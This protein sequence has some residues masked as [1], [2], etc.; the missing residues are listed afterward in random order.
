L[1]EVFDYIDQHRDEY[2]ALLQKFV[3]QPSIANSGE[4]MKEM[5]DLLQSTLKEMGVESER[6][7]TDGYPIIYAEIPGDSKKTLTFYNHYDVQPVDPIDEWEVPPFGGTI[8]DGKVISRGTADNKG[9]LL[10]RLCAIDAYRKVHGS[11]PVSIKLVYE[12]EEEVGSPNLGGFVK[13]FPE[14]AQSDGLV[15]E[16]GS[17]EIDGPAIITL[18]VKGVCYVELRVRT[19]NIDAHSSNAP[20]WKNAAW[21]LVWALSTLKNEKD[22]I[23]IDGFFDDIIPLTP[24]QEALL[25][26]IPYDEEGTLKKMEMDEFVNGITGEALKRKLITQPTCNIC[27]I[28]AGYVDK[29]SKTVLPSYAFAKVDFRL[30]PN[31]T[32]ERVVELLRKHLDK[33]GFQDVEIVDLHGQPPYRSEGDSDLAKAAIEAATEVYG[34]PPAVYPNNP[35]TMGVYQFCHVTGSPAVMYGVGNN[36]SQ[37]HAPNENIFVEDY[38]LS[39]KMSALV[40]NKFGKA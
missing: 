22:E 31:M 13:R 19:A 16:G 8:K 27:G 34:M 35:G 20:I 33:H 15:W 21:R 1:K 40:L 30:V 2:L 28:Q 10:S 9:Q 24:E 5:A 7:P 36:F 11:L 26:S 39:M 12:G 14:R 18:G 6:V 32:G 3:R 29:G 38:F 37:V 4:G 17:R 23:L 25:P